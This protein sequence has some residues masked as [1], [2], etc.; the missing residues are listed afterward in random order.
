LAA[1][2]AVLVV[3]SPARAVLP[4]DAEP[5]PTIVVRRREDML[6]LTITPFNMTVNK[7]TG[8][9]APN[10]NNG[11]LI[12]SFGP[13]AVTEAAVLPG[14]SVSRNAAPARLAG[15]SQLSFVVDESVSL[16][17]ASL[18]A[19]A[20]RDP[21]VSEF[22]RYLD[23]EVLPA[24]LDWGKRPN[25]LF[26]RI[27]MPWW[28]WLSPHRLSSWTEQLTAK[29]YAGRTEIFHTRLAANI[30]GE[31]LTEDPTYR[32]VRGI[33]ISDPLASSLLSDPNLQVSL[34]GT[35]YPFE[36]IPT[37]RDRADIV[38][39]STRTG[40]DQVGGK[41]AAIKARIA[42]SAL[43]GQLVAEGAW[44]EP[45]VS[46]MTAWQQRIWQ[47]RDTYAKVVRRGFLYPWG[48]KAAQIE[49][50]VRVFR[51]DVGGTIRAFW[52]KRTSIA[53]TEPEVNIVDRS[54][55]TDAGRR[56]A[57]FSS[58]TCLTVQTPPLVISP[59]RPNIGSE[60][61]GLNAY[62]PKVATRNGTTP[63]QFDLVGIDPD[64]NEIPFTQPLLFAEAKVQDVNTA[65]PSQR[66]RTDGRFDLGDLTDPNFTEEGAAQLSRYYDADVPYGDKVA[67][68]GGAGVAFAENL[69]NAVISD[70]GE[71][72]SEA[73][74]PNS[75]TL[76][77]GK[78]LF[79]LGG[80]QEGIPFVSGEVE[81]LLADNDPRNVPVLREAEVYLEDQ[82]RLLEEEARALVGPPIEYLADGFDE[83]KNKGQIFLK[84]LEDE[85]DE[86]LGE[87][88]FPGDKGG[89][90]L[91]GKMSVGALSRTYGTLQGKYDEVKGI[92]EDGKI[93]P[94]EAFKA[95]KIL[96]GVTLADLM[97][98]PFPAVDPDGKPTDKVLIT[99]SD[100]VDL[101]LPSERLEVR[102]HMEVRA[103]LTFRFQ[104][105]PDSSPQSTFT[106]PEGSVFSTTEYVEADI[107]GV[108]VNGPRVSGD[109][110]T[111]T[112]SP[113][114][115]GSTVIVRSYPDPVDRDDR[116]RNFFYSTD[117]L[118]VDRS[119]LS[120]DLET[121]FPTGG[122]SVSTRARRS[123]ELERS[124]G[125]AR[126]RSTDGPEPKASWRVRGE[127]S[128][129]VVNLVPVDGLEFVKV[130]ADR[131]VFTAGS[132]KSPDVD[133]DI[134]EID[135]S[136]LLTLLKTLAA[137]LPFGD[138]L[139]IDVKR[140]GLTA[141]FMIQ[142]PSIALGAFAI[143]G[144]GVGAELSIPFDSKPVRFGFLMSRP[145]N[146]FTLTITGL[147]GGGYLDQAL[148]LA[149][150]ERL[151]ITGFVAA[152][153]KVDFG[154]AS[155]GVS[156]RAGFTF[157]IGPVPEPAGQEGLTLTAFASLNGHVS[158]LGIASATIDV[159]I[160]LSVI[161]P[162]ALPAH[163]LLKGVA[164]V[165]VR[166]SVALF[167]KTVEFDAERTIKGTYLE[168]AGEARGIGTRSETEVPVATFA[169]AWSDRAWA[170]FCGAF[171]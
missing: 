117:L 171:G 16:T 72:L 168:G 128:D 77:A 34:G 21:Y 167:S 147:G 6:R 60:W 54:T 7:A 40:N 3:S 12:V 121:T 41:A 164:K 99:T 64:G 133:V 53:I 76:S 62:T 61:E 14:Q 10:G 73:G 13:Q 148:G 27:E 134:R 112:L 101:G 137:Y 92:W 118:N 91:S 31:G 51:A 87:L 125:V 154:V 69:D 113:A 129:F 44:D 89:G 56:A 11:L 17:L 94:G 4:R 150:I 79:G 52:E 29:T 130:Y 146:P 153:A 93:T 165:S 74:N 149:G 22:G 96:G 161:V 106:A 24:N 68:F 104:V 5:M 162:A 107:N 138:L 157:A 26:T 136:G 119:V 28:L 18:L 75:T 83:A 78:T 86:A 156:V 39:L 50:G 152:E 23:G 20:E 47:G 110:K 160:G 114:P 19:W 35:G 132:G 120:L 37:P 151:S 9:I 170:E 90:V 30:P 71:V 80:G 158:V 98:N 58:V 131:I 159:Y 59:S 66:R 46:N 84:T 70:D 1:G 143:A 100:F 15:D 45:G 25:Q 127:L 42:L 49:E 8:Q 124:G 109:R 85:A 135:F 142:L 139:I 95:M 123:R 111:I 144:I 163:V 103:F 155:G 55:A 115:E 82:G 48:F 102:M 166:V 145:E 57:L 33:W 116:Y 67:E 126:A 81:E 97:P 43:G 2:A 169:D 108:P 105:P 140:S 88:G 63:F 36:M 32:T 141:G 38:R 122:Y 65:S